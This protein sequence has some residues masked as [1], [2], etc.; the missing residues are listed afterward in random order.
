MAQASDR[1]SLPSRALIALVELYRTCV[2]PMLLPSCRFDPT[3]SSYA[4]Q[5]LRTRGALV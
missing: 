2:S 1:G 4:V 3:C 5:A